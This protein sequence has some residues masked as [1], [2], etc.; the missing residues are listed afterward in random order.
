[1]SATTTTADTPPKATTGG[2]ASSKERPRPLHDMWV[3]AKRG[4]R[5]MRRQPEA[6]ADATI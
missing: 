2:P 3:I 1:M 6:L 5:H 4:I